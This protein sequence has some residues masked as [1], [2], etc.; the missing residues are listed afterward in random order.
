MKPLQRLLLFALILLQVSTLAVSQEK[1]DIEKLGPIQSFT[2]KT[3]DLNSQLGEIVATTETESV[4]LYDSS[5]KLIETTFVSSSKNIQVEKSIYKYDEQGNLIENIGYQLDGSLQRKIVNKYDEQGNQIES[6]TFRPDGS[7]QMKLIYKYDGQGN[8]I[9]YSWFVDPLIFPSSVKYGGLM[10]LQKYEYDEFGNQV[11]QFNYHPSGTLNWK[12]FSKYDNFGNQIEKMKYDPDNLLISSYKFEYDNLGN[13]TKSS[14]FNFDSTLQS[15]IDYTY[16]SQNNKISVSTFDSDNTLQ[17]KTICEYE[18]DRYF[19]WTS[20]LCLDYA[21]KFGEWQPDYSLSNSELQT[22]EVSYFDD[23]YISQPTTTTV[24]VGATET[25]I[26]TTQ[27]P[28]PE[29]SNPDLIQG[30]IDGRFT[31]FD[32]ATTINLSNGQQWQQVDATTSS[33]SANSPDVTIRK[34][35]AFWKMKVDGVSEEVTVMRLQ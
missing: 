34:H 25:S 16:D 4:S 29:P 27:T 1:I 5:G 9:E 12:V 14:E 26:T 21:F 2:I 24:G 22:R 10:N 30:T 3:V 8:Q 19:N 17:S 28:Q 7:L 23:S 13:K 32:G 11:R 20:K 6:S 35:G 18:Y 15:Q 33:Y 31:G